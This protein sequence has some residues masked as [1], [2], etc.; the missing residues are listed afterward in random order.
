MLD[1]QSI[2]HKTAT[3]LVRRTLAGIAASAIALSLVSGTAA[4][5]S[6]SIDIGTKTGAVCAVSVAAKV[7]QLKQS[8]HQVR[9]TQQCHAVP[10]GYLAR[11]TF[12]H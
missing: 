1:I 9:V 3:P 10:G 4:A 2:T 11:V 8:G 5:H 6:G 12:W 7:S